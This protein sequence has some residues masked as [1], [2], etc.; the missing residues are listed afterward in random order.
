MN[1]ENN[2]IKNTPKFKCGDVVAFYT[3]KFELGQSKIK[4]QIGNQINIFETGHSQMS[5]IMVVIEIKKEDAKILYDE[6]TGAKLRD[7]YIVNCQWYSQKAGKFQERWLNQSVLELVGSSSAPTI[8]NP[9]IHDK[10][11]LKTAQFTYSGNN[12]L[13]NEFQQQSV[14]ATTDPIYTT[15]KKFDFLNFAPPVMAIIGVAEQDP[16]L[17]QFDTKTGLKNRWVSQKKV[18]CMWYEPITEKFSEN[19]FALDALLCLSLKTEN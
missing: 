14:A 3:H 6:E 8:T 1:T 7:E 19:F 4:T 18:K 10:V 13:K 5:P 9:S 17:S 16:K 12:E 11:I 15:S 2:S